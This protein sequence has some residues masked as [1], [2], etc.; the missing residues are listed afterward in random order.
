MAETIAAEFEATGRLEISRF[1][2]FDEGRTEH[3]ALD[4]PVGLAVGLGVGF[5]VAGCGVTVVLTVGLLVG[6]AVVC[7]PGELLG[8]SE[9]RAIRPE[10]RSGD[11]ASDAGQDGTLPPGVGPEPCVPAPGPPRSE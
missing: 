5:G 8:A 2:T 4:A 11:Q 10:L 1:Q 3:G 6:T 9:A 7:A